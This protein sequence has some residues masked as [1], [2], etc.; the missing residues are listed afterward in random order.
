[1]SNK[2]FTKLRG[3]GEVT[4]ATCITDF[5]LPLKSVIIIIIVVCG[6]LIYCYIESKK[7]KR[8]A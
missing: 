8:S 3:D 2:A 4:E 1:M 7:V 6:V 5:L